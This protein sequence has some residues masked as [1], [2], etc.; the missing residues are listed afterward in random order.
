MG[1]TID[2]EAALDQARASGHFYGFTPFWRWAF[3]ICGL[4]MGLS[5]IGIPL[6]V[7]M[8][9]LTANGGAGLTQEGLVF[10][11]MSKFHC[12]WDD[13]EEFRVAK[14]NVA[15]GGL[16]GAG[17]K[18]AS[19]S[20]KASLKGPLSIKITGKKSW[21]L[22]PAHTL[23]GTVAMAYELERRTGLRILTPEDHPLPSAASSE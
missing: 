22:L 3:N 18:A 17:I 9:R 6:T 16:V 15:S 4:F 7:W 1:T 2:Y 14:I 13:I 12:P 20:N 11:G 10:K 21:E 8:F 5:I 19:E 23:A